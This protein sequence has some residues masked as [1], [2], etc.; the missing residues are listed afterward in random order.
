MIHLELHGLIDQAK[1]WGVPHCTATY[2]HQ[3]GAAVL[4][5]RAA[6]SKALAA[7]PTGI[8]HDRMSRAEL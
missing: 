2:L 4:S 1:Q 3:R 6:L 8:A 7:I 5:S